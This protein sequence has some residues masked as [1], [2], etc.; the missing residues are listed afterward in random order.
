VRLRSDR[1]VVTVLFALCLVALLAMV[2][3]V[4]DIGR[5]RNARRSTQSAADFAA[6]AAGSELAQPDGDPRVACRD[7]VAYLFANVDGLPAT[8]S[9]PCD[10]LA[11]T[12]SPSTPS[13]TVT[14]GGTAA[15]FTIEI[16][17]PVS[18][19]AVQDPQTG[20]L[21]SEDGEP[22]ERFGVEIHE[23]LGAL[24]AGVVGVTSLAADADAVARSLPGS[25]RQA[26]NLWLLDPTGCTALDVQGGSHLTVGTLTKPGLITLDSDGSTCSSNAHTVDVGGSGSKVEAIPSNTN[27]PGRISLVA[28]TSGQVRCDDGNPRACEQVDVSAGMLVPQPIRRYARATRAAVDHRFNCLASYPDYHGI[29]IEGCPDA[30]TRP[31]YID[32]LRAAIGPSGAPP[33]FQRWRASY[34]CNSPAVPP[35]LAGNWWVDC[36]NFRV[37]GSIINF[38]GGNVVFDGDVAMTGSGSLRFNTA[39]PTAL[40]PST[41]LTTVVG[42]VGQSSRD[43][44]FVFFRSGDLQMTGGVLDVMR[45]AVIMDD[46]DF[47]VA[48]GAPPRWSAPRS[49]PLAALALWSE[50]PS[51]R[52]RINGGASME[53]EGVFFT[54][55]ANAFTLTGGSPL[56]PQKAQFISYRLAVSGGGHLTLDPEG[57]NLIE[58]APE[59]AILIR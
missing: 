25:L 7:A 57:V 46:G 20:G 4:V 18:D 24:F 40:L 28:M 42:C 59:P 2:A 15:P 27:P 54:P 32:D 33:G 12:C 35:A 5:V 51:T 49:G 19:A 17:Y 16:T 1:G 47:S 55:E 22:C 11:A 34:S 44:A 37:G 45:T 58:F 3:V 43:A 41:C 38:A 23:T 30:G 50:Q 36:P 14:D 6:L 56:I 26:P 48:G 29:S 21:R 31:P 52:F 53:L 9:V 10:S 8:T 13:T 39:N